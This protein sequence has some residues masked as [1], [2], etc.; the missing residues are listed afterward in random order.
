MQIKWNNI[1][2]LVLLIVAV[3]VAFKVV[4]LLGGVIDD[5]SAQA[6]NDPTYAFFILGL[7]CMM[8]FGCIAVIFQNLR[9]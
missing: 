1:A 2:I 6:H 8:V 5:I 7:I 9:R 4:P 3:I